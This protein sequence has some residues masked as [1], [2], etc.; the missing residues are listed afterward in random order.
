[1]MMGE[2]VARPYARALFELAGTDEVKGQ[3]HDELGQITEVVL[4]HPGL[5]SFL[6]H[7]QVSSQAKAELLGRLFQDRISDLVMHFMWVV[8]SKGRETS[9]ESIASEYRV[10][11]DKH[12]GRIRADVR[13]AMALTE[14]DH[15]ELS[16]V[17]SRA[18][19]K[20]VDLSVTV[21]PELIGGLVVR[22][23]DRVL[24]GSLARKISVLGQRLRNGSGGGYVVE[25]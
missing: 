24:D 13:T 1:M 21:A 19:G 16:Q 14:R 22:M 20:T 12:Q 18:T 23:G 6:W 3:V 9:L 7:P 10:L 25:H 17:L 2:R 11:W 4:H 8:V 15:E 5:K